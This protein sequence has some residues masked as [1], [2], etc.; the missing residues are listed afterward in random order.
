MKRLLPLILFL[1]AL[2]SVAGYLVTKGSWLGRKGM[3]IFHREY[4]FLNTWWQGTATFFGVLVILVCLHAVF[5]RFLSVTIAKTMHAIMLLMAFT[6]LYLTR[7]DFRHDLE[8]RLMGQRFHV[9]FYMFW[10]GWVI[11]C[12]YFIILKKN[13]ITNADKKGQ[14]ID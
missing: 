4:L 6:G 2:S 14:A 5:Q 9:G 3:G 13:P 1:A 8:H 12:V 7:Y 11:I 10:L